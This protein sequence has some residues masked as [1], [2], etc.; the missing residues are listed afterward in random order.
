[1]SILRRLRFWWPWRKRLTTDELDREMLGKMG[2]PEDGITIGLSTSDDE[3]TEGGES[4][5]VDRALFER[6][7][8]NRKLAVDQCDKLRERI[9]ELEAAQ[10]G[11]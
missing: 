7:A 9:R 5:T 8:L 10:H 4:I 6:M 1:M 3:R 2:L 11:R